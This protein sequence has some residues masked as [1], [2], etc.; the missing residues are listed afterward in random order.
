VLAILL[1]FVNSARYSRAERTLRVDLVG[2]Y[3]IR[4]EGPTPSA[5]PSI[6][7]APLGV[8]DCQGAEVIPF[9]TAA[10]RSA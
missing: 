7:P 2:G 10:R 1:S 3:R 4:V 5:P 8:I 9:P 6:P